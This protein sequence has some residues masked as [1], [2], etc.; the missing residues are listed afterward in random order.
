M[1]N[2]LRQTRLRVTNRTRSCSGT[3]H[4]ARGTWWAHTRRRSRRRGRH[5]GGTAGHQSRRLLSA[6]WLRL[7]HDPPASLSGSAQE[8]HDHQPDDTSR[9]AV[10]HRTVL[11][12]DVIHEFAFPF[13]TR[14]KRRC[15]GLRDPSLRG[16]WRATR[17]GTS[18]NLAR[19]TVPAH[20]ASALDGWR[21]SAPPGGEDWRVKRSSRLVRAR[22][23]LQGRNPGDQRVPVRVRR[24]P[25]ER[26][27]GLR[28]VL[29]SSALAGRSNLHG[30]RC[31]ER[32]TG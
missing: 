19:Q 15:R 11:D 22:S 24:R 8:Q 29:P 13:P 3:A 5:P 32:R 12:G 14:L 23:S 27:T 2:R 28:S 25:A 17:Y 6:H 9:Y 1:T 31:E 16:A 4:R 21:R 30:G 10:A 7:R 26:L 18:G 20:A